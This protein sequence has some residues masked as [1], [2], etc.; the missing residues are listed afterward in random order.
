M[1][2]TNPHF[3]KIT[4]GVEEHYLLG[5]VHYL[6]RWSDF[7]QY[8]HEIF[9]AS[10]NFV[11]EV[12][13]EEKRRALL[14][15]TLENLHTRKRAPKLTVD[16]LTKLEKSGLPRKLFPMNTEENFELYL[17]FPHSGYRPYYILDVDLY[18]QAKDKHKKLFKLDSEEIMSEGKKIDKPLGLADYTIG[19][20]LDTHTAQE[21]YNF[22]VDW[23]NNY[24]QGPGCLEDEGTEGYAY[25][26]QKWM[27][28]LQTLLKNH[29]RSFIA[30][31][32]G[33]FYGKRGLIE[34]LRGQGYKVE[35]YAGT[36]CQSGLSFGYK[37][38]GWR[39]VPF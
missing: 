10:P 19:H 24:R 30:V 1:P 33:H 23:Q 8:V 4:K 32:V 12:F 27:P 31:G 2:I 38:R 35:V 3:Y 39:P 9:E 37:F 7:P 11:N 28:E 15:K 14:E 5:T 29:N 6:I 13:F 21:Y 22:G 16:Q 17:F 34:L 26:T 36:G 18:F 20:Y 25:R